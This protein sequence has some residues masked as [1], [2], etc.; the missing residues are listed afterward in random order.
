MDT[1]QSPRSTRPVSA[2]APGSIGSRTRV[3]LVGAGSRSEMY[4]RAILGEHAGTTELVA[5]ADT[6]PGRVEHYRGL[7]AE[8]AGTSVVPRAFDP[9]ELTAFIADNDIERVIITTPDHTHADYMSRPCSRGPTSSSRSRSRSTPTSAR[10]IEDAVER[11][12]GDVLLTFNYRYSPRNSALAAGDPDG[13]IGDVT[14]VDFQWMLDT[15][16]GADYFRRWHREKEN[17]GG[18]LVHK[19]SHHFDLVN[20]WIHSTPAPRVRV[21]A[22]CA[23]TA[24]RTPP[25]AASASARPAARGART[26]TT[27]STWTCAPTR[28][29]RRSTSTPR[30]TTA[31]C[32]TATCSREGITIED[33]LALVVDYASGATLSYSLNAHSPV[34]GLPGR[35]QRHARPGRA[36]GRR[37]RRRASRARA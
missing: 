23:S 25:R 31:T 26:R 21:A 2:P 36:G 4:I 22:G 19:A 30:G 8:L 16:H 9:A 34:G 18:L 1:A 7:A 28:G 29:C 3:V 11:T 27:R 24:P 33:N 13:A 12:G 35:G 6:N 10:R 20:W 37:A 32:A 5:L 15:K 14:S 17:S